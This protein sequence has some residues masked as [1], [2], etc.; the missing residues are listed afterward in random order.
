MAGALQL[1]NLTKNIRFEEGSGRYQSG[2]S[3]GDAL[4][5]PW[6]QRCWEVHYTQNGSGVT[7]AG[8]WRCP[9]SGPQHS[10]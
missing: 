2:Y 5:L 4:R 8:R 10:K 7:Q 9:D 6:P 3:P 1:V